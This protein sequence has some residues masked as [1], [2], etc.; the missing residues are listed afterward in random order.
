MNLPE[1]ARAA[2][3]A[4]PLPTI[5]ISAIIPVYN[6]AE[7]IEEIVR[8]L[9]QVPVI[10]Q[11]VVVDDYSR[12]GTQAIVQRLVAEGRVLAVF[13]ERNR[14]KGAAL[15]SGLPLVREEYL[16][17]QDADLEYDP[18]DFMK[19]AELIE[20]YDAQV[21]Y[22]SRFLGADRSGMLWTHYLGNRGLTLLFNLMFQRWI[23]DMET[24]YKLFRTSLLRQI[25]IDNDRFDVDPELTAKVVRAGHKI[26]ETSVSYVGRPYLAGKKIKPRDAFTAVET[27]WRYRRWRPQ[28]VAE[29][30]GVARG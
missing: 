1:R 19:M 17:I 30:V 20:R 2:A 25:G 26:Y 15:R 27:L 4:A 12:D 22:G 6:E 11:I 5:G 18:R 28:P 21:I 3:P 9:E 10:R 24:C 23:T 14:G 29:P 7:T 13:H 8:R 16:A